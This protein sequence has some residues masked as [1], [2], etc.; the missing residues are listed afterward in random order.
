M[1]C[2][3]VA[4]VYL[5]TLHSHI[6]IYCGHIQFAAVR[7]EIICIYVYSSTIQSKKIRKGEENTTNKT[8]SY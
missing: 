8:F 4:R 5:T 7:L 2:L 3:F 1:E 6:K